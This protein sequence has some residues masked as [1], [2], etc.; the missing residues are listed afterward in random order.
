M[1][2]LVTDYLTR[3]LTHVRWNKFAAVVI[4]SGLSKIAGRRQGF[5]NRNKQ[6]GTED[7][8]I[9]SPLLEPGKSGIC[10]I[11]SIV[12]SQNIFMNLDWSHEMYEN[13]AT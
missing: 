1:L 8:I 6:S 11:L 5:N 12:P 3:Y 13:G 7:K 2:S 9:L 4:L 10:I